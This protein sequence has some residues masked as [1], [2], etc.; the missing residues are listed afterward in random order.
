MLKTFFWVL[1]ALNLVLLGANTGYLGSGPNGTREPERIERQVQPN[2]IHQLP[3]P[4]PEKSVSSIS[5]DD[6]D[7]DAAAADTLATA[8]S[9]DDSPV[10]TAVALTTTAAT[11]LDLPAVMIADNGDYCLEAS[12][13]SAPEARRFASMLASDPHPINATHRE[14]SN[15][16]GY[17]VLLPPVIDRAQQQARLAKLHE[18]GVTDMFVI[19]EGPYS[20]G[21]SLGIF[22]T[23]AAAN[24]QVA[25]LRDK[26]I[27]IA[28]MIPRT[29]PTPKVAFR[30]EKLDTDMRA[31]V[32]QILT[33]FPQQHSVVCS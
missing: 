27:A 25:R 10:A 18:Q 22:R 15:V 9:S 33:G 1:L 21:V 2:Q 29:T 12:G 28:Q 7:A 17:L 30:L 24:A 6:T 32:S 16:Q 23:A 13:F 4:S 5:A 26:G 11:A 8:D 14:V 20:N 3:S 19:R 31:K